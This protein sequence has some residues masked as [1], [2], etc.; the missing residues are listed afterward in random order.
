MGRHEPHQNKWCYDEANHIR[1]LSESMD[2]TIRKA[3]TIVKLDGEGTRLVHQRGMSP[4]DIADE[5][6]KLFL[7]GHKRYRIKKMLGLSEAKFRRY[8]GRMKAQQI[9]R[10]SCRERV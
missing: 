4:S 2:P 8:W 10:A 9:G 6:K 5:I 3:G 7:D 1:R